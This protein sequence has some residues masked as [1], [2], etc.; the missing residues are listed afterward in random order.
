MALPSLAELIE[1]SGS[2]A[3]SFFNKNSKVG[4][5]VTGSILNVDTRQA[6]DFKTK[7]PRVWENG[8]PVIQVIVTIQTEGLPAIDESDDGSRSIFIKF[9]GVQR[10]ALLEALKKAGQDDL[11]IGQTFTTTFTGTEKAANKGEDDTK[12]FTYEIG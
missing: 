6:R 12:I 11:S 1:Q 4:D 8:D 10:K 3:P 5:S 9:W 7:K 2:S